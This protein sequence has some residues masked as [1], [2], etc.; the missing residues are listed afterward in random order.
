MMYVFYSVTSCTINY[1]W[2]QWQQEVKNMRLEN[3][4]YS[5]YKLVID[6]FDIPVAVQI[7]GELRYKLYDNVYV[8]A[9]C[10]GYISTNIQHEGRGMI[11]Q[12]IRDD[13]DYFFK[14]LMD[15]GECGSVNSNRIKLIK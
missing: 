9:D 2:P 10:M 5:N 12:I 7:N 8:T 11:I 15:N 13:T 4:I 14:V 1:R 3:T 6:E